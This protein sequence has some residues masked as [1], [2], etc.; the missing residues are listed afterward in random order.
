MH[1]FWKSILFS[2]SLVAI[3][4]ATTYDEHRYLPRQATDDPQT[5]LTLEDSQVQSHLA[6]SGLNASDPNITPSLTSPNNFINFCLTQDVAL[7]NGMQ[8]AN[9]SCNPTPMGRVLARDKIPSSKFKF[10][11]NG[12]IVSANTTFTVQL[13]IRNLESGHYSNAETNFM[14]APQTVNA[15][16]LLIGHSHIVI[17]SLPGGYLSED[18]ME[19]ASF[20][21]FK[22][23]NPVAQNGVLSV[24][25]TNGLPPG[26][27]RIASITTA[28]NH[29]PALVGVAQ[30]GHA[31]DMVYFKVS[32]I[33]P[34]K[35]DEEDN[36]FI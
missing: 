21:F 14:A 24:A 11:K 12:S 9:G 22:A 26:I 2:L 3:V 7:T 15:D 8:N 17:E 13:V 16:G 5:N 31:D 4:H 28:I 19:P 23:L 10:P 36:P 1:L 18:P 27:Y 30:H 25:V 34:L 20:T 32:S 6:S 33:K 35:R 29:Q